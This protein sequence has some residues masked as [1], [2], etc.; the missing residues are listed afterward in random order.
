MTICVRRYKMD[1]RPLPV[2]QA[3]HNP[4]EYATL[5]R[6]RALTDQEARSSS[7]RVGRTTCPREG[8]RHR[9]Q[10]RRDTSKERATRRH[11]SRGWVKTQRG[12]QGTGG[13]DLVSGY[14]KGRDHRRT[15]GEMVIILTINRGETHKRRRLTL[16]AYHHREIGRAHV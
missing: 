13:W 8:D 7:T 1:N 6:T 3:A 10:A 5:T 16:D 12:S 15:R 11:Y 4:S 2:R 9:A 14:E